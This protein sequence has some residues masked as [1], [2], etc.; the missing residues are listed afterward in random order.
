[1]R[2]ERT[3]ENMQIELNQILKWAETGKSRINVNKT[4][5]LICSTNVGECN[6]D[7]ELV[8]NGTAITSVN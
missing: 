5:A 8:L 2:I 3:R 1:M 7:P 4:R 6:W